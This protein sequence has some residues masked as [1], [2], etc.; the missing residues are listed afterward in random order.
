MQMLEQLLK[1]MSIAYWRGNRPDRVY[2]WEEHTDVWEFDQ[3]Y[4][5]M[6]KMG[7]KEKNNGVS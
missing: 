2:V 5:K 6:W 7:H 3:I 1:I 4:R